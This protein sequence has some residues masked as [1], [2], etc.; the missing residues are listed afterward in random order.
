[1]SMT[2]FKKMKIRTVIILIASFVLLLAMIV[3]M[4]NLR[5]YIGKGKK[6]AAELPKCLSKYKTPAELGDDIFSGNIS[7]DG[8]LYRLPAPLSQFLDNGWVL[9]KDI[10]AI[11]PGRSE[12]FEIKRNGMRLSIEVSNRAAYKT[13]P[14]NCAVYSFTSLTCPVILPTGI[15]PGLTDEYEF[16]LK[17]GSLFA[18]EGKTYFNGR[19]HYLYRHRDEKKDSNLDMQFFFNAD[20]RTL[21]GIRFVSTRWDY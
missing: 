12:H 15:E 1:M 21:S 6:K 4:V 8:D 14:A 9:D 10:S 16:D 20:N 5:E 13:S 11:S 18:F 19:E 2:Q 7:I 3:V 17:V